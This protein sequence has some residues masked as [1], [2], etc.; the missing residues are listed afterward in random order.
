MKE[1]LPKVSVPPKKVKQV[2]SSENLTSV[3]SKNSKFIPTCFCCGKIDHIKPNCYKLSNDG[4]RSVKSSS[5]TISRSDFETLAIQV[6]KIA[7]QFEAVSQKLL[8]SS[9]VSSR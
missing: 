3:Y 9:K 2:A 5:N 4:Y 7:K 1:K 8:S 6:S